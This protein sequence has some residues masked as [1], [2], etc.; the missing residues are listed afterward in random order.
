METKA[1]I[2][3]LSKIQNGA[4]FKIRWMTELP[5]TA[6]AKREGITAL[7]LTSAT[8]R[9]GI[10]YSNQKS[11]QLKVEKEGKSLTSELPWGKWHPDYKGL[12]IQHKDKD[13]IRLY[14]SPN[15]SKAEYILNGEIVSYEKLKESG[16]IQNSYFN[17]TSESPDAMT[18]KAESI[19]GIG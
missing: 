5:L 1:I 16:Y 7:K 2:N 18:L 11:V 10:K 15:K 14:S 17:K 19:L 3:K 12:V 8:M 9:K 6:A 4:F 13:Y